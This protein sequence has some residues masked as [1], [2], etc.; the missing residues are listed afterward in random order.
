MDKVL[1]ISLDMHN[2]KLREEGII[3]YI[4]NNIDMEQKK[5]RLKEQYD[6]FDKYCLNNNYISADIKKECVEKNI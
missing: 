4:N 5:S 1:I 3:K 2:Y 6:T